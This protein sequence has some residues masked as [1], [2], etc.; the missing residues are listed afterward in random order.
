[1]SVCSNTYACDLAGA[2][3]VQAIAENCPTP[4]IGNNETPPYFSRPDTSLEPDLLED[5]GETEKSKFILNDALA[6]L[7]T[8]DFYGELNNT[9]MGTSSILDSGAELD[10]CLWNNMPNFQLFNLP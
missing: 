6:T 1:M 7:M 5:S 9:P 4:N 3:H 2:S 8:D 10:S